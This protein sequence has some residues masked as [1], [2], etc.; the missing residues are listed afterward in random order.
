MDDFYNARRAVFSSNKTNWETPPE[1]FRELDSKYHFTLDPAASDTNAKCKHYFTKEDDGL[2]QSW[3]GETVFCNPPY[4]R[5]M[6]KWIEKAYLES[7]KPNTLVVL[8]I[9][10]RTDTKWFHNYI[11]HKAEII[12]IKGRIKFEING[13]S[14]Q[15]APFPSMI[16]V[17]KKDN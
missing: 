4:G 13:K 14:G 5:D 2:S 8:L 11:Y 15:S 12:F 9:P 3:E 6:D 10:A 17:L 1:L 16:A 7:R